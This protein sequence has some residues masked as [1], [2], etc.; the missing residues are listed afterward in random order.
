MIRFLIAAP[1]FAIVA[2]SRR[3]L[4]IAARALPRIV[5][6]GALGVAAYQLTLNEGALRTTAGI[7]S[8]IVASCP[9]MTL[10]I[11]RMVGLE[12][13]TPARLGGIALAFAGILVV[14][15]CA[16]GQSRGLDDLTGPLWVL[17]ASLSWAVYT[18]V[19]KPLLAAATASAS[20]PG[21]RS[22]APPAR[23]RSRAPRRSRRSRT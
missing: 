2:A 3:P 9:A 20:R 10:L 16:P 5:L 22:R 11:A 13:L 14:A 23:C 18:I 1:A 19:M 4:G 21:R 7:T 15:I 6:G 17:A 12:R 8:L